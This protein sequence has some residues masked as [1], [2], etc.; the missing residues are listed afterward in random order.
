MLGWFIRALLLLSGVITGWFVAR[1]AHQFEIMQMMVAIFLFVLGLLAA[2][3]WPSFMR[4]IKSRT[5][6]NQP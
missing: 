3:F 4:W 5:N 6:R 2:A 1:D